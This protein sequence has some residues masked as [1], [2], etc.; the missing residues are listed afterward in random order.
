[1]AFP[2][3]VG[4]INETGKGFRIG[5]PSACE[6]EADGHALGIVPM[7]RTFFF[8][9]LAGL[10]DPVIDILKRDRNSAVGMSPRLACA[11]FVSKSNEPAL[12]VMPTILI[13]RRQTGILFYLD[14][15]PWSF[16]GLAFPPM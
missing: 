4:V 9:P 10:P 12:P 5:T 11:R 7:F 15:V 13:I 3:L 8:R 6:R 1:A 2:V 14:F 16:F